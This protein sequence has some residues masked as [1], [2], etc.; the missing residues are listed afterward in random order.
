MVPKCPA[1]RQERVSFCGAGIL[2]CGVILHAELLSNSSIVEASKKPLPSDLGIENRFEYCSASIKEKSTPVHSPLDYAKLCFT[3][4]ILET[5]AGDYLVVRS[6][7]WLLK[8]QHTNR[9]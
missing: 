4:G 8:K 1:G 3:E 5:V 7:V 2:N 6:A 9:C